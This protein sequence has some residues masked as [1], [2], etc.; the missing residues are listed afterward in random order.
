MNKK[1]ILVFSVAFVLTM[2]SIWLAFNNSYD[3][4]QLAWSQLWF[5]FWFG[6]AIWGLFVSETRVPYLLGALAAV[7]LGLIL[8]LVLHVY[9]WH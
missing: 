2:I 9:P 1:N 6:A 4:H 7:V 5:I 3:F 8:P